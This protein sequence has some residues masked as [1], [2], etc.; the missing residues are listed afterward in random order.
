MPFFMTQASF[1]HESLTAM[2]KKL[3]KRPDAM[4]KVVEAHGGTMREFF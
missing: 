4:A 3:S 2:V 1:T